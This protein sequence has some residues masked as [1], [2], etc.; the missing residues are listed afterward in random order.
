MRSTHILWTLIA[1]SIGATGRGDDGS[2]PTSSTITV[3]DCRILLTQRR[4]ISSQRAG[5]I[6]LVQDEGVSVSVDDTLVQLEDAVPQTA[7]A[8]AAARVESDVEVRLSQK[9]A[10]A[11]HAEHQVVVRANETRADSFPASEVLRRRLAVEQADLETELARH[12]LTIAERELEQAQAEVD[13][14]ARRSPIDGLIIRVFKRAGESVQ[15]GEPILEV[16][17]ADIVRV[18]GF[19]VLQHVWQ[20]GVGCP[21]TVRLDLS[22]LELPAEQ[23]TFDGTLGFVDPTTQPVSRTVRVWA[24]IQNQDQLLREGLPA[25]MKIAIGP[26]RPTGDR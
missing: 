16:A 7:L 11:A 3:E 22:D 6:R 19:V 8:A 4:I 5:V 24:D 14:Y 23:A 12:R 20:L 15:V 10:E 2:L 26:Q 18:E 25:R 21:V 1:L 9:A 17:N 13:A